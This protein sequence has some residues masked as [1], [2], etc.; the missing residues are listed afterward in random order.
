MATPVHA[1]AEKSLARAEI[2]HAAVPGRVRLRHPGLAERC[3][4]VETLTNGLL[5]LPGVTS[6][7]ASAL[8]AT[9]LVEFSAPA[10]TRKI[11]QAVE[12]AV[13]ASP[14]DP[15]EERSAWSL[16]AAVAGAEPADLQWHAMTAGD[17]A[18]RLGAR[19]EAGL[20][21]REAA[22]RS[23][24]HGRNEIPRVKPRSAA[25]IFGDQMVGLPALLLAG[26]AAL[27]LLT[28]GM[29]DAAVIAAVVLLNGGIATAT[30]R[31]A[32]RTI[33]SLSDYSPRP[34]PVMRDGA[35]ILLDPVQIVRGDIL[36][37]ERGMLIPA[38]ARLIGAAD[39]SV[40]ESSLTGEAA[41]VQK[42]AERVLRPDTV[43]PERRNMLY[44][45]TAVT[46]GCA[47]ALVTATGA[48]TEIGRVER[49]LGS[50][51]PPDTPMQRQLDEVERK[52]ILIN[53][54]VCAL[55]FGVGLYRRHGF[56]PMLR[57]AVSLVVAAIPEGLPAV[58]TTTLALGVEN[59]R[60]RDVLV[61]KLD[62]VET[63]GAIQ[64]I[65][66]DKTGTLTDSRMETVAVHVDGSLLSLEGGRLVVD[67]GDDAAPA[68]SAATKRLLEVAA[69]CSDAALR[70]MSEGF[71][72]DGTPT[73]CALVEAALAFGVDVAALRRDAPLVADVPR[74][75]NR[76]RMSTLHEHGGGARLLCVKGDPEEV[77][78]CCSARAA[79]DG[80]T[81]LDEASRAQ[82]REANERMAARALRVL[83]VAIGET[84]G[85][86]HDERE[87]VWL[88]LVGLANP[89]RP[90]VRPAL[91]QLHRAGIR[92]VMITG[93]QSATALAIARTLDLGDGGD[94]KV[95]EAGEIAALPPGM[96]AA[97]GGQAQV[98]ARVSPVDKLNIVRALQNGGRI[99][100]M[101]GDGVNDG[102]ALR[103]S[104]ISIAM[105][106]DGTD[107]A[108]EVADMVLVSNDLRGVVE[109]VRLGRAT[110]ANI[111]KVLRYLIS[112]SVSETLA[113]LGAAL[114]D[115]GVAM[116]S[117]QLLWLN[118]A[119]EPLPALALGLEEPDDGLLQQPP[120]DPRA[121]I[122]TPADFG[123]LL[124][125]GAVL[126]VA[127]LAAYRLA[128]GSRNIAR[129]GTV[130]FHGLTL[131]QLLHA[132]N[133]RSERAGLAGKLIR[134]P[135]R[136]LAGAIV[137]SVIAQAAAQAFPC[138]RRILRLSPLGGRELLG[139]AG[140][141]IG[142]AAANDAIRFLLPTEP[143]QSAAQKS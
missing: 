57:N 15:A 84:G 45:G 63:L 44:R 140:V 52:L 103:A 120:R 35:R 136:K 139:V 13:A 137:L 2:V 99:V 14:R 12:D 55:V 88:G 78:L 20:D 102:P 30:E 58:A 16:G 38:D 42:E 32:E 5:A 47:T 135:N 73:E 43:L 131:G 36:L 54:L 91:K 18:L 121:P 22:R 64:V 83:G 117:T 21:A 96:L 26:S 106:G 53:A 85:D 37:L 24:A 110:H 129:A 28:G 128:G 17:C 111:R 141:A 132:V 130:T 118:I 138:T 40:D 31:R 98:F 77:L 66:L 80:A 67:G 76:K 39:F 107:V 74:S 8:T 68:A 122:L 72:V 123:Y 46:G 90:S 25:A 27:S 124:L 104:N 116:T 87:L 82:I 94:I 114:L 7:R 133:C 59:M 56:I 97:L 34:V 3:S 89:I 115:G 6:V 1:N 65:G 11:L 33:R 75:E 119:G 143:P 4:V 112:T 108:R 49:L 29:I 41:P 105:G 48:T 50:L 142:A 95:L 101:T 81:P 125:E 93:D 62:A 86:P 51:R 92:S 134:S 69:L 79:R 127:T 100:G 9:V 71:R 10:S 61:R 126:G 23:A 113:M 70:P 109:A 60:R 19:A